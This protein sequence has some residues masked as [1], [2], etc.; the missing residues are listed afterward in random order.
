MNKTSKAG[1]LRANKINVGG[2]MLPCRMTM[3]AMRQFKRETGHDVS[4]L[5]T[6]DLDGLVMLVYC[7]VASAC[8]A[9]GAD[10]SMDVDDFADRLEPDAIQGFYDGVN[11]GADEKKTAPTEQPT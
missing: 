4:Q 5:Q 11:A 10:F 7:C 3:G 9:D 2:K 6:N 8:R 1:N